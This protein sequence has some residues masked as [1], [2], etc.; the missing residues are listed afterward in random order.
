MLVA[1][2]GLLVA[3]GSTPDA[4]RVELSW[5]APAACPDA[6]AIHQRLRELVPVPPSGPLVR[7]AADVTPRPRGGWRLRLTLRGHRL[8]DRRTIEARDCR[9]LADVTA[10]LIALAV[11]PEEIATRMT[12]DL[13]G[14][15][16]PAAGAPSGAPASR[17]GAPGLPTAAAATSRLPATPEIGNSEPLP[18]PNAAPVRATAPNLGDPQQPSPAGTA[19]VR[20]TAPNLGAPEQPSSPGTAPVRATAPNLGDPEPPLSPAAA[21]LREG[22]LAG[23]LA[24]D[25]PVPSLAAPVRGAVRIAGGG[26]IGGIPAFAPAAGLAFAVFRG[27]WRVEL[28]G[29]YAARA[30]AYPEPAG[31]GAR[32]LL[33]AGAV[34]ACGVPRW[35]RLEFPVCGGLELGFVRAVAR[36]VAA[37]Q[38]AGDLWL[39]AQ[40]SPGLVWAPSRVIAVS[41]T[42]DVLVALRRPGFHVAGL[43]ELARAEAVG[44]RPMLGIEARFP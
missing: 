42:L 1:L 39:A 19:P 21:P 22:A 3:L 18:S 11:A 7:A 44:L 27:P 30:L 36:G 8:D 35:R 23:D 37:P 41:F 14:P 2:A 29:T 17:P 12:A 15:K 24:D 6:D 38:P 16:S 33:A 26:E 9:G 34:R 4:P 40:L 10:L 32:L 25:P 13:R 28:G 43:G 5:R 31:V 20:A